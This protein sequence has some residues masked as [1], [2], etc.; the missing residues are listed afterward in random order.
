[1]KKTSTQSGPRWWGGAWSVVTFSFAALVFGALASDWDPQLQAQEAP[2]AK[3]K[4]GKKTE[5][6]PKSKGIPAANSLTHGKKVDAAALAK[7]IDQEIAKRLKKEQTTSVGLCSDE[8]FVRR[9]Y[10]DIV[11][12]IPT[13]DKVNA[14]L[15]NKDANKRSKLIDELLADSRFGTFIAEAWAIHML[16]RESNNRLLKSK[17][18]EDW[19][20]QHFNKGTPLD[21]IVYELVTTTG[22]IDKN[23]A[24]TYFVAN[25]T[26]DKIT[27][28][29]TRMFLGVQLQCAQ[30]HNHPFTDWKQTEYWA[31]AAFFM[32]TRV[33]GS[34]KGAAKGGAVPAVGETAAGPKGKKGGLPESAKIVP[35]KFLQGDQPK[36]NTSDPYRPVLAKWMTSADNKF[37]ARAMVNRFWFQMF[38]RGLVNPVDD[39]HDDNIASHPELLATLTEQFKLHGFDTKYLIRAICNSEVYQRSSVSKDDAANI[40]LELY[41]RR[42]MRVMAPEQLYD[43]LTALLGQAARGDAPKA[44]KKGGPVAPRDNFINFFR[45]DDFNPLDYQNGI[46]QAL[47]MM[48]SPFTNRA[49]AIAADITKNA[50]TPAESLERLYI[51]ALARRPNAAELQRLTTYV[52]RPGTTPRTA[53]GDILWV[54]IN[55]SEFVHNH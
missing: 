50:K 47:R 9:I 27:D 33:Q 52:N 15:A 46:P 38:G 20:A 36:L 39:M 6:A 35:A 51:A 24:G 25:P 18:M 40:D 32:K 8:E 19:L 29:V 43:S 42:E 45:V 49:E 11:G 22:D 4:V 53:Y 13:V 23:P 1:M 12:V 30:C 37:F 21:K 54:L 5:Y 48:N 26:V 28:N 17:P 55:S 3:A 7:L 2:K 44:A 31:M 34:A 16:P 10:L 14:F 41:I